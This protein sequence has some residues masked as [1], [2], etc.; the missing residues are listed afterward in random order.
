MF[1]I[2]AF[3]DEQADF[4]SFTPRRWPLFFQ[5]ELN[6]TGELPPDPKAF[7]I[8]ATQNY[9]HQDIASYSRAVLSRVQR[10]IDRAFGVLNAT[11]IDF[12]D[13]DLNLSALC[14]LKEKTD[15]PSFRAFP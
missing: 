1:P 15:Q 14:S 4:Y 3:Q 6:R 12:K 11:Y 9:V 13:F 5:S 8:Y 2:M 10:L 7:R